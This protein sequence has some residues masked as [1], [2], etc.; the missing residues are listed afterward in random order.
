MILI[1]NTLCC[2]FFYNLKTIQCHLRILVQGE[3]TIVKLIPVVEGKKSFAKV[4]IRF[5]SLWRPTWSWRFSLFSS[6][7]LFVLQDDFSTY[8]EENT[9]NSMEVDP[10]DSP[11][12]GI[13]KSCDLF[14]LF[15]HI[16]SIISQDSWVRR[17]VQRMRD[18]GTWSRAG[19]HSKW[20]LLSNSLT[21][22]SKIFIDFLLV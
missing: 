14:L 20:H 16:F 13:W 6:H 12:Q 17:Q 2:N 22:F 10:P 18:C 7:H 3:S 1:K 4:R 15:H 5:C 11:S 19:C 9:M 21:L 8:R